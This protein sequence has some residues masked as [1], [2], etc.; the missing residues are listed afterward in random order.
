[1]EPAVPA[2]GDRQMMFDHIEEAPRRI[3]VSGVYDVVVVGGG[4]AGVAAAVSAARNAARVC[5]IERYCALGGLATLG[6]VIMWLPLCDGRGR[7]VIA[8]LGEEL[9]KL[10][11][12]DLKHDIPTARFLNVPACWRAQSQ[13]C[14]AARKQT[15]YRADFNPAAYLLALEKLVVDA[16]V[17]LLYDTRYC[18]V[19]GGDGRVTHAIVENKSGRSAL[20][21]R[22]IVDAT[23]DADVC[24]HA[25]EETVSLDTNVLAG[26]F[27]TLTD[28][29]LALQIT[30]HAYS[31]VAAKEGAVGPFFR[32]DSADQV[33]EHIL[34]TRAMIR[35]RL[36]VLRAENPAIDVQ[37]LMPATMACLRMTRRLVGRTTIGERHQQESCAD[38]IG[39]TGDWR[40]AGPI[41]SIPFDALRGVR[42]LNLIAAGRCISVDNTAW[43]VLRAIPPCVV[44]GEAAGTAAAL[45]VRKTNGDL[46]ALDYGVLRDQLRR[47]G[48]LLDR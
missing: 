15:R 46:H 39:L 10:S 5:L 14:L 40:D 38:A 11:V 28:N 1:M 2:G 22:T 42:N 20:A 35:K 47:Q 16:G 9:L 17:K 37:P 43:D 29:R 45:A 7:Q 36:E 30:S 26:W 41:Y 8:G 24:V 6:N 34:Q 25:G 33:T 18:A 23:G 19:A 31:P 13:E 12:A 21:C 32:G 27:Y 44:T 4:I 48:V 3:P